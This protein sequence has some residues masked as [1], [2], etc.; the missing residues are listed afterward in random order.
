MLVGRPILRKP[1]DEM[2]SSGE[3]N[4]TGETP[5]KRLACLPTTGFLSRVS[6]PRRKSNSYC[7][8]VVLCAAQWGFRTWIL[9]HLPS[10]VHIAVDVHPGQAATYHQQDLHMNL[11]MKLRIPKRSLRCNWTT[12]PTYRC[13]S[14]QALLMEE[15]VLQEQSK[16]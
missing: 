16:L 11:L 6:L 7:V 5:Q 9:P 4:T 3:D 13:R 2:R 14:T 8:Q 15:P 12:E 1:S 10:V